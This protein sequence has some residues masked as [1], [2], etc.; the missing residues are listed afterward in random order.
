LRKINKIKRTIEKLSPIAKERKQKD[1]D[2]TKFH[3][4]QALDRVKNK[5][6]QINLNEI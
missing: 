3:P 2:G 1:G 4:R 5:I 6:F